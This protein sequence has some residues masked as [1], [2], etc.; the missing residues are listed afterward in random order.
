MIP[1]VL[2]HCHLWAVSRG[3]CRAEKPIPLLTRGEKASKSQPPSQPFP[4]CRPAGTEENAVTL[5]AS[6]TP[7]AAGL[8]YT[9]SPPQ[10]LLGT[11]FV[12]D[13]SDQCLCKALNIQEELN[14]P[15]ISISLNN[16]YIGLLLSTE[17]PNLI[18]KQKNV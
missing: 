7:T 14:M 5:L 4:S 1:S 3:G 8:C 16:I 10:T 11:L 12:L 6:R 2:S 13:N 9:S 18:T 15:F 17:K